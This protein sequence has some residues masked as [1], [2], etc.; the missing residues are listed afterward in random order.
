MKQIEN[1]I[2]LPVRQIV[3]PAQ[4]AIGG[5]IALTGAVIALAPL[6]TPG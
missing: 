1:A 3:P 2:A 4:L 5:L 6:V